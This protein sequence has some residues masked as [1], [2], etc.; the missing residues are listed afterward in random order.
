M[1]SISTWLG[2][3]LIVLGVG[4]WIATGAGTAAIPAIFG[5]LMLIAGLLARRPEVGNTA[6]LGAGVVALLGMLAPL[7]N[8][9]RL[10]GA[11]SFGLNAATFSNVAMAGLC[12]AF[13]CLW[14]FDTMAKRDGKN[15]LGL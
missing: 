7:G 13:L 4:G 14:A 10:I 5:L 9:A 11:Q 8:V 15:G 6:I 12:A 1:A 3:A 2:T